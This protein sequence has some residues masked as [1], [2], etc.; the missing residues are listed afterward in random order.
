MKQTIQVVNKEKILIKEKEGGEPLE[1]HIVSKIYKKPERDP[2]EGFF[3]E[4]IGQAKFIQDILTALGVMLEEI[5]EN[6]DLLPKESKERILQ[7][8]KEVVEQAKQ[9]KIKVEIQEILKERNWL[10]ENSSTTSEGHNNLHRR[11]SKGR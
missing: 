5:Q 7:V 8:I 1:I 4:L 3:D 2:D 11:N 10:K 6:L 9:R